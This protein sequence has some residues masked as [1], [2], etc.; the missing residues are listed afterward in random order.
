MPCR[1]ILLSGYASMRREPS[2]PGTG[3]MRQDVSPLTPLASAKSGFEDCFG[4]GALR[5]FGR[6]STQRVL[7]L[8]ADI[9]RS[10]T[11]QDKEPQK[12]AIALVSFANN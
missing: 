1:V 8:I 9:D 6:V 12:T 4:L 11:K 10:K 3:G 7:R 2:E 5:P